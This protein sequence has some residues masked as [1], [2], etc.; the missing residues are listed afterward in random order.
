MEDR[1]WDQYTGVYSVYSISEN[2]L[3]NAVF[4]DLNAG[5]SLVREKAVTLNLLAGFTFRQYHME[6]YNALQ[7]APV[8][9]TPFLLPGKVLDY[10]TN[11]TSVYLGVEAA[12][13][14][15]AR[16]SL[17]AFIAVSPFLTFV[18]ARDIHLVTGGY[19]QD[20]PFFGFSL[21]GVVSAVFDLGAGFDL[22]V[23]PVIMWAPPFRGKTYIGG[24]L[25][26]NSRGGASYLL[27]G[28]SVSLAFSLGRPPLSSLPAS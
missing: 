15:T 3:A 11:F 9:I 21:S 7:E 17:D 16:F 5:L 23:K 25:S 4:T 19:F 24:Y 22:R 28:L 12:W 8:G 14:P 20:I 2:R 1:D 13:R 27:G 26:S 10:E 18:Y 6:A